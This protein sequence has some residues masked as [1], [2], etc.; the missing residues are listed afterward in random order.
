MEVVVLV[1]RQTFADCVGVINIT[2]F[3]FVFHETLFAYNNI[4]SGHKAMI[5]HSYNLRNKN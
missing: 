4:I 2:D 1:V 5:V 3:W